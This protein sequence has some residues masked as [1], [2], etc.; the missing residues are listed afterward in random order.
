MT[1]VNVNVNVIV[2][3]K[4]ENPCRQMRAPYS[5]PIPEVELQSVP[6]L[7]GCVLVVGQ[8]FLCAEGVQHQGRVRGLCS[9]LALRHQLPKAEGVAVAAALFLAGN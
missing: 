6:G 9:L 1:S 5:I 8:V 3:E 7:I 2:V 4:S